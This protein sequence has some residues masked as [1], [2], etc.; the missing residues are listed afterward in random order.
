MPNSKQDNTDNFSNILTNLK[1]NPNVLLTNNF[2]VSNN[3]HN[4]RLSNA[5]ADIN[6]NS[7]NNN[8]SITAAQTLQDSKYQASSYK[9]KFKQIKIFVASN[10]NGF[11]KIF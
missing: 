11:S 10:K 5:S 8:E 1:L 4:I 9:Y 6:A 2:D 3:G 7:N